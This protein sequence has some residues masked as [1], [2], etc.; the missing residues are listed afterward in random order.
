MDVVAKKDDEYIGF[1][2]KMSC[3]KTVI[4]QAYRTKTICGK[5]YV[6]TPVTP[7]ES[8]FE[9]CKKYGVGIIRINGSIDILLEAEQWSNRLIEHYLKPEHW[10]V[11]TEGNISGTPNLKG[12]GPAQCLLK[13][14]Q[15]YLELNPKAGWEEIYNNVPNHYSN[16]RSLANSMRSW[17]GFTL[18]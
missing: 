7:R 4:H 13:E 12:E 17:Q 5:A 3:S 15:K 6:V 10:E 18:R 16:F 9:K 8:S 14:I 2:L 1:E 11:M